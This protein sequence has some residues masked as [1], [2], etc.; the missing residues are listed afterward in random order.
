MVGQEVSVYPGAD[1]PD[2]MF[3][4]TTASRRLVLTENNKKAMTH[5]DV[6]KLEMQNTSDERFKRTQVF[7]DEGLQRL[8]YWEVEWKGKVGIA[9][10]YKDVGRS[11]DSDGGLG[12]ND[13]SWSLLCSK[14]GYK[15]M[16]KNTKIEIKVSTCNK[17]GVFLDWEGGTL[18]Y[19]SISSEKRSLIHT[20]KA[21]FTAEL[22]PAF[23]FK[24][25]SVT[26]CDL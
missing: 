2:L 21:K 16:H 13:K 12:T 22:F 18:S 5:N 6:K 11:W 23:W 4:E 17:I 15:A 25:G 14:T 20:F 9:V 3:D 24:K 26:L 7:C 10:A 19:Y 8:C 1:G